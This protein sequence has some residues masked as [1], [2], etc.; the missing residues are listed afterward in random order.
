L[1][2]QYHE[3]NLKKAISYLSALPGMKDLSEQSVLGSLQAYLNNEQVSIVS[4]CHRHCSTLLWLLINAKQQSLEQQQQPAAEPK[5]TCG[6]LPMSST[7]RLILRIEAW[8]VIL[9]CLQPGL[10]Q[11]ALMR[12]RRRHSTSW[13]PQW[14][15][16]RSGFV[17]FL[18]VSCVCCDVMFCTVLL[19]RMN[20]HKHILC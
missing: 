13:R 2:M 17:P 6:T 3:E 9:A 1:C 10:Y 14:P 12:C 7:F 8:C 18:A 4:V 11:R 19:Y 20:G 5:T 15:T 16:S